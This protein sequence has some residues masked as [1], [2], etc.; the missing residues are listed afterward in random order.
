MEFV[1]LLL[2]QSDSTD[3]V[4]QSINV[5]VPKE[6]LLT[7]QGH[8]GTRPMLY[9]RTDTELLIYR[10]FRYLKG[11]LKIRF[12]KLNHNIILSADTLPMDMT[13]SE[14]DGINYTISE[15]N[16]AKLRYFGKQIT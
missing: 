8:F 12:K 4:H 2:N 3:K 15:S 6:I 14:V 13:E 9:I 10:V 5:I 1:P 7:G 11:N 16:I